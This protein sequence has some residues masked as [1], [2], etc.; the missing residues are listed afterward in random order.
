MKLNSC[1]SQG[2]IPKSEMKKNSK[3]KRSYRTLLE[4]LTERQKSVEIN[5]S[6]YASNCERQKKKMLSAYSSDNMNKGKNKN[7]INK[8]SPRKELIEKFKYE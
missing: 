7:K 5:K 6:K 1:L 2:H 8:T 4:I 3:N